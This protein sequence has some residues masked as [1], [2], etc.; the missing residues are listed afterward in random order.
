MASTGRAHTADV[1]VVGAGIIG[2]A[3]AFKLAAR[4]AKVTVLEALGAPALGSTGRSAA[5]VRVQFTSDVN[6]RLSWTSIVEYQQ[7][8]D[9]YGEDAGYQALGYLFLVPHDA[10]PQHLKGVALQQSL[11]VPVAVLGPE[12]AQALISFAPEGIA[13]A[14]YGPQDG[15]I[16]PHQVTLAYLRLARRN[17]AQVHLESPVI[18]GTFQH[19]AWQLATPRGLHEAPY[20]VNAAGAWSGLVARCAGLSVPVEPVRRY[21]FASAPL[22]YPHRFPLTIDVASGFYLRSEGPRILFG[23]SNPDEAPGFFEG[24]DWR[25]LEP[26]LDA[27]LTRFPWLEEAALDRGASWWGYYE[28]TPDHNPILGR[29]PGADGWVNACGFS[30]HGVQQAAAVGGLIAEEI[31]DGRAHSIAIDALRYERF[32]RGQA[33]Q[34]RHIV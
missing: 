19:G 32:Q 22:G 26:T 12:A 31:L 8:G 14:T 20:V 23:R 25:W 13:G 18:S 33:A 10:W 9:L 24:I 21:V 34:E 15:V 1:I 28:M 6:I 29:M 5:G 11:N 3:C 4:G 7:F 27:G 30:G 17:G 2:A 16:D